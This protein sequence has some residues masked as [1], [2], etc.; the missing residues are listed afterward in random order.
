MAELRQLPRT[1][2]LCDVVKA[3][4]GERLIGHSQT[5]AN[6]I[7]TQRALARLA[8]LAAGRPFASWEPEPKRSREAR[9]HGDSS[10]EFRG[11]YT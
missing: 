10:G 8:K 1:A 11:H 3:V 5:Y 9:L 7:L 6:V 2:T 4:L